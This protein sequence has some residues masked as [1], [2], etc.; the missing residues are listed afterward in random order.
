MSTFTGDLSRA[1]GRPAI[2]HF[3]EEPMRAKVMIA[4]CAAA[5]VVAGCTAATPTAPS[6]RT[7]GAVSA[8]GTGVGSMGSGGFA[9][10]TKTEGGH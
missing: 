7:P 5:L 2:P 1:T 3:L 9:D 6:T 4:A 10:T 8:D